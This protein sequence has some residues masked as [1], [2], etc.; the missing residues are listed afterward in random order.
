MKIARRKFLEIRFKESV[1]LKFSQV[2][3]HEKFFRKTVKEGG[4]GRQ[5]GSEGRQTGSEGR[6][7]G[8]GRQTGHGRS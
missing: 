7:T 4:Q 6:Q 5:T 1:S 8:S 3:V 2:H